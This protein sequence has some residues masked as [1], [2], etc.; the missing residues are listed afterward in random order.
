ML[1]LPSSAPAMPSAWNPSLSSYTCFKG[2]R[3]YTDSMDILR[4][5]EQGSTGSPVSPCAWQRLARWGPHMCLLTGGE[6]GQM[7]GGK[8]FS[9]NPS[10]SQLFG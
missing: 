9:P 1:A 2:A 4:P 3:E 7:A 8:G 5:P 10:F 6:E